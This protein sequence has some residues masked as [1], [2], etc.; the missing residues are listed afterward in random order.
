MRNKLLDEQE[1]EQGEVILI[2]DGAR[3]IEASKKA[4]DNVYSAAGWRAGSL[5]ENPAPEKV[6]AKAGAAKTTAG[7]QQGAAAA[8]DPDAG[9]TPQQ[10]AAKTR[11]ANAAAKTAEES[12]S[13]EGDQTQDK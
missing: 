9:L 2:N 11:A 5:S 7:L 6:T 4:F 12:T 13:T 10:K 3:E 1:Y 8:A